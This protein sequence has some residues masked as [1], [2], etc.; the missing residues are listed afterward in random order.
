MT[1]IARVT[2]NESAPGADSDTYNIFNTVVAC[3]GQNYLNNAGISRINVDIKHSHAGTLKWYKSHDRG[4]TWLQIDEAAITAPASTDTTIRDILL[5]GY[6][7]FKLDWVNGGSA[8][9]TWKL[10]IALVSDR[11]PA[12]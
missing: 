3:P 6:L 10:D 4:T 12:A 9:T 2:Y 8:Q 5:E 1:C 7:D 11:S